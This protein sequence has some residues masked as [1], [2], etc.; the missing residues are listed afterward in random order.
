MQHILLL[1]CLIIALNYIAIKV[2]SKM[3]VVLLLHA[4][5]LIIYAKERKK[6]FKFLEKIIKNNDL[7][8]SIT[9]F[10]HFFFFSIH[11]K[12]KHTKSS[13]TYIRKYKTVRG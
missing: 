7:F 4:C 11:V 2:A 9:L 3:C 1:Y 8:L 13:I 10:Y 12:D 5:T 6:I